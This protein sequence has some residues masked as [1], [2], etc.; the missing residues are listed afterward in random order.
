MAK[1]GQLDSLFQ[2]KQRLKTGQDAEKT[3]ELWKVDF[4]RKNILIW[5]K[6]KD[7]FIEKSLLISICS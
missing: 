6:N 4:E 3:S 7:F 1:I 2:E 5:A